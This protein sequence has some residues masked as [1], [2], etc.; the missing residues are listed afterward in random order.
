MCLIMHTVQVQALMHTRAVH[1]KVVVYAIDLI[2]QN[3]CRTTRYMSHSLDSTTYTKRAPHQ[4]LTAGNADSRQRI[5]R[6]NSLNTTG[7][8]GCSQKATL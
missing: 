4:Q 1:A 6:R 7:C 3:S 5:A 2:P 8:C